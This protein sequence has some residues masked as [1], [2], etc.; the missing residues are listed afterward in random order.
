MPNFFGPVQIN[1]PN[2][3]PIEIVNVSETTSIPKEVEENNKK[4]IAEEVIKN[5]KFN[6]SENQE[7]K[8]IDINREATD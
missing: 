2:I 3:I 4:E 8:K 5:K 7:I 1:V 6:N